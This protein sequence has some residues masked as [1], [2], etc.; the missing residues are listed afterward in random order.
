LE[1]LN[2]VAILGVSFFLTG[3]MH[4]VDYR[5]FIRAH[6]LSYE[7]LVTAKHF[8]QREH[9][10][11]DDVE[12]ELMKW[13]QNITLYISNASTTNKNFDHSNDIRNIAIIDEEANYSQGILYYEF[14]TKKVIEE[15]KKLQQDVRQNI[16]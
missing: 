6:S 4:R 3:Y 14:M 8:L 12:M 7:Y 16:R 15:V 1:H 5:E 10:M 13:Y 11:E 9:I 2:I